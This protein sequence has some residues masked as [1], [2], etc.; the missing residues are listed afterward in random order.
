VGSGGW[1]L[2]SVRSGVAADH[3][4]PNYFAPSLIFLSQTHLGAHLD[5]KGREP[6]LLA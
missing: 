4:N 3:P 5:M 1:H 2:T 6:A